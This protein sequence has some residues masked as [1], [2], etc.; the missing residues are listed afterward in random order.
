[1]KKI[2]TYFIFILLGFFIY[3]NNIFANTNTITISNQTNTS[4]KIFWDDLK[5]LYCPNPSDCSLDKWINEASW[6]ISGIETKWTAAEY[7]QKVIKYILWFIFFISVIIIIFAWAMILTSA[8]NDDR[9]EKAKKTIIYCIIWI[10]VIALA[11]PITDFVVNLFTR[12][13]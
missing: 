3:T 11:Y 13:N 8:W 7:V 4:S 9:V 5:P 10:M 12:N 1:M 2:F 6:K